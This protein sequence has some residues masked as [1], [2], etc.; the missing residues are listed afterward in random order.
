MYFSCITVYLF[1]CYGHRVIAKE[2]CYFVC[3]CS[4]SEESS[5]GQDNDFREQDSGGLSVREKSKM[6]PQRNMLAAVPTSVSRVWMVCVLTSLLL[7][8]A[9]ALLHDNVI[10]AKGDS[11]LETGEML[12]AGFV[13]NLTS[14]RK[15][16]G[17][18]HA[19]KATLI[20]TT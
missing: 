2:D 5:I 8:Q 18:V 4:F 20:S 17:Q 10:P 1:N 6:F 19:V 13:D 3:W 7:G 12:Q 14:T 9:V 15:L 16:V 11:S